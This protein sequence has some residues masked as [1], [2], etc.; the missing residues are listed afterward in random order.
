MQH[1]TPASRSIVACILGNLLLRAGSAAATGTI[2]LYLAHL[3]TTLYS[4]PATFLGLLAAAFYIS[5]LVF[6][7]V[8]GSL[9]DRYG[10]K[11][12][13]LIGTMLGAGAILLL[14]IAPAL[15]LFAVVRLLE[16]LSSAS[17]VPAVLGFLADET[18]ASPTTRGRTMAAFEVATIV[19]FALGFTISGIV[20]D[21][22]NIGAF[23]VVFAVYISALLS[24]LFVIPRPV[25][26]RTASA[27]WRAYRALLS[28]A[29]TVRFMPSWVAV[30]AVLGLW[31]T[32]MGFQLARAN[33]PQ[34]LLVGG[35]SGTSV[36]IIPGGL[37]LVLL[38]GTASWAFAFGKITTSRIMNTALIAL[39][40]CSFVLYA[41]NHTEPNDGARIA[42]VVVAVA[43]LLLVVSGFTPA[44]L[45]HL[46]AL[47]EHFP[48]QRGSM[49]G[50]YSVL[51]AL[52]QLLGGLTGGLFAQL[53]GI[54][55]MILLTLLLAVMAA[56]SLVGLTPA[57]PR[58]TS[59]G[60][61]S[62]LG[63]A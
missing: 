50:L 25:G 40:G 34:Q 47:S 20:W 42:A 35:F 2:A 62:N 54:D 24:F 3:D 14:P 27:G 16:G 8:F 7:P 5:E 17:S 36:G 55:G 41:L 23:F 61:S 39:I 63:A 52:G 26:P 6:A 58:A 31:F 22:L 13:M 43:G 51:L 48:E 33:D 15:F 10:R 49:M 18:G 53:W 9:S 28:H 30:N 19:G 56:I 45:A 37:A 38:I 57:E 59:D 46:A 11:Q 21:K 32:H 12:F 60:R 29:P 44:A 1:H 4:V